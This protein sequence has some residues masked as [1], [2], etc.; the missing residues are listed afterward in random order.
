MKATAKRFAK[1]A[2]G[3]VLSHLSD[4][5]RRQVKEHFELGF[6]S[7]LSRRADLTHERAHYQYFYTTYFGF[8]PQDYCAKSILDIGCGP[9][10]SLE[11]A[12]DARLRVGLDPLAHKYRK[13]PLQ[14]DGDR[15]SYVAGFSETIPFQDHTFDYVTSFN[16]L[17]HVADVGVTI[18]EMKRV[19]APGGYILLIVEIAHLP[20]F[21]EPHRLNIAVINAFAP[22]F[23]LETCEVFGVPPNHNLWAGIVSK[24]PYRQGERG[25][26][27]AKFRHLLH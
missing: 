12:S 21:T 4:D 15:M 3:G 19:V 5:P 6:W 23:K 16:S 2:I 11:W 22:E 14:A 1:R 25:L 13:L 7:K 27:C 20:T 24:L 17:D 26:L 18:S 9:L 10:G 8:S